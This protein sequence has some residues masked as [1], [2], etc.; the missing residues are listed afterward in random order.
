[1]GSWKKIITSGSTAEL[2]KVTAYALLLPDIGDV[3]SS[4]SSIISGSN[5]D[6]TG[7]ITTRTN[8][9]ESITLDTTTGISLSGDG[10]GSRS[11]Q[12]TTT[13]ALLFG[14]DNT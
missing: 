3:S 5:I 7:T 12:T 2:N 10:A 14:T 8:A 6:I 4:L 11:L 1:M 9:T 13:D